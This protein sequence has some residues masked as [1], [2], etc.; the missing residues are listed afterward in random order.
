MLICSCN[1]LLTQ[2][3]RYPVLQETQSFAQFNY[4]SSSNTSAAVIKTKNAGANDALPELFT[5]VFLKNS[6]PRKYFYIYIHTLE[7]RKM[8]EEEMEG[9]KTVLPASHSTTSV[10]LLFSGPPLYPTPPAKMNYCGVVFLGASEHPQSSNGV[11]GCTNTLKQFKHQFC[12]SLVVHCCLR[13]Y[14]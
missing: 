10:S 5:Y 1:E 8:C 9:E 2:S 13:T 7:S 3:S 14:L 12:I 4:A 6:S 11:K